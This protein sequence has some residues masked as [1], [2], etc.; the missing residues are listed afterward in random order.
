MKKFK[1]KLVEVT[2]LDHAMVSGDNLEPCY[3][4]AIGWIVKEDKNC[5][6]LASWVTDQDINSSDT[7]CYAIVKHRG[8]KIVRL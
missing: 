4:K 6:Y 1:E 8:M 7:E 2:F 3:C 5:I